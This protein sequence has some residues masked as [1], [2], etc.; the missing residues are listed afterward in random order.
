M[1]AAQTPQIV[2]E[3]T[4]QPTPEQEWP[5]MVKINVDSKEEKKEDKKDEDEK[6]SPIKPGVFTPPACTPKQPWTKVG[7]PTKG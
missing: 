3:D 2:I 1:E 7:L 5:K 6:S 4:Q